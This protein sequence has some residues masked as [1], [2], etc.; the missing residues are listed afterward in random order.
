MIVEVLRIARQ[1]LAENGW[2][3]R[4]NHNEHGC[5][6]LGAICQAAS[7]VVGGQTVD[8]YIDARDAMGGPDAVIRF[9]DETDHARVGR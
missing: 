9:N 6:S 3:Q 4:A 7:Q 2:I 5:C 1:H 8:L